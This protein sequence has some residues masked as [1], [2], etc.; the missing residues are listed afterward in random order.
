VEGGPPGPPRFGGSLA[1]QGNAADHAAVILFTSG[2]SGTPKA[3]VLSHRNLQTNRNQFS[4]RVDFTS[5]DRFF[6]CLP[7]FHAFG[8]TGGTLLPILSGAPVFMYPTP[9]HYGVIPEMIYQTNATIFFGTNTFLAGYARRAHPYDFFA[10]RYVF[11][12]AEK[13]KD[14]IRQLF[15]ERYGVRIFE[16]YGSTE[17]APALTTN[18]PM[19]NRPGTVG[20]FFPGITWRV[21]PV[22]GI[23]RGG[24]LWVRGDNIMLGY[25]LSDRPGELQPPPDGWYDTGDVVDVDDEGFVKILGRAK[26]FAKIAGE[27]VSL[28]AVEEL[29]AA[30]WP[31]SLHA[32]VSRSHPQKGEEIVLL[33]EQP[34]A[35]RSALL[36]GARERGVAELAVPRTI[37]SKK[38][39]PVL[40]SGKPD[41]VTLEAEVRSSEL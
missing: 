38:K 29:A 7:I 18:T 16:G 11:A 28:T 35:Q 8:L 23:E 36:A 26:R 32:A 33:T 5:R 2:S 20:R 19:F 21:D 17:C 9:L 24:R 4:A 3:V 37:I 22:P 1:L 39:L 25:F 34:D 41:Y 27:M 13:L 6:N 31:Q 40:G 10:V 15:S 12:G 30:V 14:N